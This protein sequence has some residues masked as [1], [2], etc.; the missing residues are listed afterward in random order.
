M[1]NELPNDIFERVQQLCAKGDDLAKLRLFDEAVQCYE[2]ALDLLP[3]S[4]AQWEAATWILTA[5]G[6]ARLQQKQFAKALQPLLH[7]MKRP[8]AI[9]NPFIHLRLGQVQFE[10]GNEVLAKDEFARAYMGG[11]RE[12]FDAENPKYWAVVTSTL[13]KPPGGW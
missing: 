13:K 2:E 3:E 7:A 1:R 8:K 9:G 5:I 4:V 11:G 10:L 6:D 12:I